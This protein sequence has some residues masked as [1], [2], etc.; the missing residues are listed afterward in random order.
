MGRKKNHGNLKYKRTFARELREGLRDSASMSVA[1]CCKKWGITTKTYYL[2][3]KTYPEF[4]EAHEIGERDYHIQIEQLM[5]HNATG[6]FKGNSGVL[7]LMAKNMLGWKDKIEVET[8]N[9]NPVKKIEIEILQNK[10][11]LEH[12]EEELLEDIEVVDYSELKD[13]SELKDE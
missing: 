3:V 6:H 5:L 4:A 7:Q 10:P 12:A 1:A 13:F 2:W 8:E 9:N 11:A